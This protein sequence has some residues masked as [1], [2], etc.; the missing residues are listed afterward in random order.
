MLLPQAHTPN[1]TFTFLTH[2]C[3]P[4]SALTQMCTLT[5]LQRNALTTIT[6]LPFTA[7]LAS[8]PSIP[9]STPLALPPPPPGPFRPFPPLSAATFLSHVSHNDRRPVRLL[10][11][12]CSGEGYVCPQQPL[13]PPSLTVGVCAC[14][15]ARANIRFLTEICA[16]V[17]A[18]T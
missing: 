9:P 12:A 16:L 8:P 15:C 4:T 18:C 2:T 17:L 13:P 10:R 1:P 11:R 5:P 3:L 14:V 7:S 6:T